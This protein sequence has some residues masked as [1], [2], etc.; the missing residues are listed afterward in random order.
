MP[1]FD[2][3]SELNLMEVDNAVGQASKELIQRFDFKGSDTKVVRE[4]KAITIESADEFK[5]KAALDVLH[6]KLVK[7]GVSL[8][9]LKEEKIEP[10]A[11]GRAKLRLTLLEGVDKENA[12]EIVKRIKESGQKVQASI[13][14]QQVRVSG[15]KRDD[16]QEVMALL[17]AADL[18]LSL[19]FTNFRD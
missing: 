14:D 12:K 18:P 3:V 6:S 7:R 16:L 2:V 4:D 5:V 19:Q 15:K 1:S 13:Q 10:S 8:K 11:R 9:S 17:R